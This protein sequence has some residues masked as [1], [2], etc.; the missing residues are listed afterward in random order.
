MEKIIPFK[1]IC[2][3]DDLDSL[4]RNISLPT[5]TVMVIMCKQGRL[6][7]EADNHNGYEMHEH[8][9][10]LC[11]PDFLSSGYMYTPDF[12]CLIFC[13]PQDTLNDVVYSC[14][15]VESNWYDKLQYIKLHPIIHMN[16]HQIALYDTYEQLINLH[17]RE[18]SPYRDRI[19]DALAQAIIF[20]ML[21]IVES[22]MCLHDDF[23]GAVM[24]KHIILNKSRLNQLFYRFVQLLEANHT[25]RRSVRWYAEEMAI[26][27]KYL[28][29][30]CKQVT[31]KTPTDIINSIAIREIKQILLNTN[32][33]VKEIAYHMNYASASSFCKYFRLQTGISPQAFRQQNHTPKGRSTEV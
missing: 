16:D 19:S 23:A 13:V 21:H 24:A 30:I 11:M 1:N 4:L 18:A 32:D 14:L 15:R 10:M 26:T 27:P 12:H 33:T 17:I 25:S 29:Y 31:G 28:T 22:N 20:E 5:G 8:D 9:I 2:V 6:R 3:S 7:I